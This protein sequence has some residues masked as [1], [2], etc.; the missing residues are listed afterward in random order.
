MLHSVI[1]E[2]AFLISETGPVLTPWVE[3]GQD[4]VWVV[5][6]YGAFALV[7]VRSV[8]SH[9]VRAAW[10]L[11][12]PAGDVLLPDGVLAMTSDGPIAGRE[13]EK[14]LRSEIPVRLDVIATNDLPVAGGRQASMEEVWRS[15]LAALPRRVIQLPRADGLADAI[16]PPLQRLLGDLQVRFRR[17][18]DERWLAIILAPISPTRGGCRADFQTQANVLEQIT[19]WSRLDDHLESR[20][21]LGDHLLRRRLLAALVGARRAFEVRWLPG[22]HPVEA[23][24]RGM[25]DHGWPARVPVLAAISEKARVISVELDGIGDP[26]VS[27][28]VVAAAISS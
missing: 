10:R 17:D 21:R 12:T 27:L 6:R 5:D 24:V 3:P 20:V 1:A 25:A 4:R 15:C 23:R 11:L 2:D 8:Q 19:A 18:E 13:V 14:R 28:A 16:G 26:I 9:T 7:M 22:Y